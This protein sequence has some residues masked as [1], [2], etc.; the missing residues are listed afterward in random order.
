MTSVTSTYVDERVELLRAA[1]KA[2]ALDLGWEEGDGQ[3]FAWVH[4]GALRNFYEY[5][6]TSIWGSS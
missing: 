6:M 4:L 1:Y 5:P 2:I 3:R